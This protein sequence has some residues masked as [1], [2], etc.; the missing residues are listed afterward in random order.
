M[1]LKGIG[2]MTLRSARIYGSPDARRSARPLLDRAL[3][4]RAF[5]VDALACRAGAQILRTL[6]L[7][8]GQRQVR[9][10]LGSELLFR[11]ALSAIC[12][13]INWDFLSERL[14]PLFDARG[15]DARDLSTATARDVGGWLAG[16]HRSERIRAKE[17]A[18]LLR[19]VGATIVREFGGKA[20][21]LLRGSG[22]RLHGLDGFMERL[23]RV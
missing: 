4:G 12:H 1:L 10:P 5:S 16:Y 9:R 17:R 15:L 19:D 3:A 22:R 21:N 7:D 8:V 20:E 18:A 23:D 11:I 13:Q 2:T 6:R 14:T